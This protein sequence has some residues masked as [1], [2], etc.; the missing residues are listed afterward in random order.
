MVERRENGAQRV[1]GPL[2]SVLVLVAGLVATALSAAALYSAQRDTATRE[3]TQRHEMA[4]RAIR[5]E[6][7]RY[8][9]LLTTLAAGLVNDPE[10]T[11]EDWDGATGPLAD[12]R[13]IGAGSVAYVVP[14][15]TEDVTAAER[16]WRARGATV[17]FHPDPRLDEH[18]FGVFLRYLDETEPT[19]LSGADRAAND[20][21]ADTLRKARENR[22]MAV[23]DA[24][25][26]DRDRRD[27]PVAE[28]Q[29]S[30]ILAVPIWTRENTPQFRGWVTSSL[31]GRDFLSEIL[32]KVSERQISG[33][34][35]SVDADSSRHEVASWNAPGSPDLHRSDLVRVGDRDWILETH[36]DFR[37]LVGSGWYLPVVVLAAGLILTGMLAWLVH[38]LAT[39]RARA[40][41]RVEEATAGLR[42]AEGKSRR[43]AELL[44][45]IMTTI[46]DGVSVIDSRG[47]LLLENPA[48]RRL[49]GVRGRP[50]GPENWQEH[51][52]VFRPDGRTPLPLDEMPLIRAL[53]G[54]S[55]DG[56]EVLIRNPGH[57]EGVLLSIDGRPLDPSAGEHGA[58]AVCRDVT[59]LR[60]YETDLSIFA[61]VVAH[62]LKAP[63]SMA[64]GHAEL[65]LEDVPDGWPESDGIRDGLRRILHAVDR[66][67]AL[68]E[69]M[70]AYTTARHA[71]L[72]A[73]AVDP[74]AMVREIIDERVAGLGPDRPVPE[75]S[76]EP[77]PMVRADPAML[78]HVLDNLIGNAMKYVR[79]GGTPRVEVAAGPAGR[80][81]VRIEVADSGIGIP[82][83]DKP[84]IFDTFHRTEAA[85]GYAGT[86]LG[87]TICQR[88]VQRHGGEIGVADNPGGGTR[89]WF[90][91]P[92]ADPSE[93]P[94]MTST[95]RS[96][97]ED[98][99]A[100][101]AALERALA[102]RAAMTEAASL[103]GLVMP[104]GTVP[105]DEP[106]PGRLRAPIPERRHQRQD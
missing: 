65:V 31:R 19:A 95:D 20:L 91:L 53:H 17:T 77:L 36:G 39:G 9:R 21:L 104:P 29:K 85:A 74:A 69:T 42:E 22:D 64:R 14:V 48:A 63:L 4:L 38:V 1:T 35:L 99:D 51:Y 60:R 23:S 18:Y 8:H 67:D 41:A 84:H 59:E 82:D 47:E 70:L 78:R 3:M 10:L 46:S 96:P 34:L 92:A 72:R 94:E 44:G 43:Q 61:G 45:A 6:T 7:E 5:S 24:Y 98:E 83:A 80:G 89:F 26:L 106:A 81:L 68:I 40:R 28:Q 15:R 79:P 30:F 57:P 101:R 87:L 58:V 12:A 50:V 25:V 49:L 103:A 11:W 100:V 66:M 93:E 88:I 76:L 52:G 27:V 2:L 90:T 71:P 33:E 75:W 56:V 86:G 73:A 37:H 13:L 54:E 105:S 102:E 97:A 62:D 16:L 32:V 55:T